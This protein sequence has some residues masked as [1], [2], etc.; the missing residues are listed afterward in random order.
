[1]FFEYPASFNGA[2]GIAFVPGV[3]PCAGEWLEALSCDYHNGQ[4]GPC[5]RTSRLAFS[6]SGAKKRKWE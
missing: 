2:A 4:S 1:M 5:V 3:I 6:G